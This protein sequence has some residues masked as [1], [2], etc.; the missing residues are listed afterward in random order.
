ME[1][2]KIS[3]I[4]PVYNAET[5]LKRCV[6]SLL[7]QTYKNLEIILVDD[8]STDQS[9]KICDEYEREKT[10]VKVIHKENGGLVSAWKRGVM[11]STGEYLCFI[12]SDDWIEVQMIREMAD[13]LIGI[14]KEIISSDYVIEYTS[15]KRREVYQQLQ[16]GEYTQKGLKEDV[17]H[18][19][20][21]REKRPVCLS[22][23]MKL[24]SRELIIQNLKYSDPAIRMGEDVMI[25]LP[26]LI[27]C[28][29]LVIMDHKVYYH[30]FYA[31]DSMVHRYDSGLYKNIRH[32]KEIIEKI[33]EDKLA[34]IDREEIEKGAQRE[35]L[36]LLLLVLKNEARGNPQGY[37]KNILDICKSAEV[38]KIVKSVDV[39][40]SETSNQLLYLVLRHPNHLTVSLLRMAM[41]VY[42]RR[43]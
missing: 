29:R 37:R 20:L 25:I 43:R 11:E 36:L 41:I 40:V 42:Y 30:Y 27:D 35:Y 5:Y 1:K 22:R 17:L 15:G 4:V 32:L 12:D 2:Y 26:A 21:G 34:G 31:D 23:C 38:K 6:D 10:T 8:G 28:E 33:L 18:I 13:S 14:Q 3:L 7:H 24:I 19:L 16:P 39:K 9:G